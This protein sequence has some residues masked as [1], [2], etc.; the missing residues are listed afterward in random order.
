MLVIVGVSAFL[1]PTMDCTQLSKLLCQEILSKNRWVAI[2]FS[3]S[4][5]DPGSN[6]GLLRSRQ[7]LYHLSPFREA[8]NRGPV[9]EGYLAEI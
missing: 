1:S 4:L 5:P 3:E 7:I 8:F 6:Q 9:K 2:P